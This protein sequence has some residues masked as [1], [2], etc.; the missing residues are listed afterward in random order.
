MELTTILYPVLTLGVMGVVFGVGL[1]YAGVMFRVE[2]DP[3]L[4]L[5]LEALPGANCGGCGFPGC[6]GF[7]AAVIEGKAKPNGCPVGGADSTLKICEVLGIKAE[8]KEREVSFVKCAGNC[9]QATFRYEYFGVD[10]CNAAAHLAGGGS[11]SCA[12]GCLGGGSCVRACKFDAIHIVD[13]IAL[14]DKEK[15][16]ACTMC[17][18]ACPNNLI[19]LVPYSATVKVACGSKDTGKVVRSHC[20]V[21]CIGCKACTKVCND[22]AIHVEDN[23]AR[24]TYDKCT[25]CNECVKKCPMYTIQSET[26]VKER[27]EKP[28]AKEKTEEKAEEKEPAEV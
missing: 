3:N 11:K 22:D 19:E 24:I 2:E 1:G 9:N 7:A 10:D 12:Y 15:C 28:A 13:G 8:I 26:F 17:V 6:S 5:I 18:K 23:L 4:P 21:G 14:V 27:K 25:H 16:T 20:T